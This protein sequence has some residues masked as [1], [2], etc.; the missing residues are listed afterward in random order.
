[1]NYNGLENRLKLSARVHK[2]GFLNIVW[3]NNLKYYPIVN[4]VVFAKNG[5][6]KQYYGTKHNGDR[7]CNVYNNNN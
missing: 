5:H 3:K 6:Y 2:N 1:M 7:T 4:A